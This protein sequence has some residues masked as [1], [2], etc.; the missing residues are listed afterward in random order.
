[1]MLR[2]VLILATTLILIA[3]SVFVITAQDDTLVTLTILHTNDTHS[4]HE[5]DSDGGGAAR[6]A[7]VI[8]QVRAEEDNVILLD[9]GDRFTGTL[10]HTVYLGQD[11]VRIMNLMEYDAM[12]LGNHEFD[13][14]DEVLADFVNG[15]NF[16]VLAA[17]IDFSA[18][19]IL[20]D[21]GIEQYTIVDVNG[22]QVGVIGLTTPDTPEIANPGVDLVFSDDLV[23]IANTLAA[24]LTEQ[25][26]NIIVLLTHTGINT[27]FVIAPQLEN[28]DVFVGGHSHSLLSN[29]N[30]PA[31]A[32]YPVVFTNETTEDI[33]L[34]VQAQEHYNYLGRLDLQFTVDGVADDWDGDT[35]FLSPYITPDPIMEFV[36][37]ELAEPIAAIR[38]E[39]AGATSE[40]V[41]VGDRR[42]CRV[43]ECNLGNLIADAQRA[44]TGTDVAIMNAGGIRRDLPAT[45]LTLGDVLEVQPF[46]NLVS[47]MDVTGAVLLQAIENGISGITVGE[48]GI[49]SRDGASG[50]FPQVS[51]MRFSYDP[52][53]EVGN[54]VT[55]IEIQQEDGSFAPLDPEATYSLTVPN[56]V[57][58]GGD[59]YT[60]LTAEGSNVYLFGSVDWEVTRDY[61][62]E[63][64]PIGADDGIQ[65][66]AEAPRIQL[67]NAELAPIE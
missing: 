28:I 40:V 5:G 53:L 44:H 10:F 48:G 63:I 35:I 45:D 50:R 22:V 14:G 56:F 57:A 1:M 23:T 27:D 19:P 33:V 61:M 66:D 7:T 34:Y 58:G 59:G 6:M 64:S 8:N 18:S 36:V 55:S 13:N 32:E 3:L 20:S 38:A 65:V 29:Q 31:V 62:Q 11:N 67:E 9:G 25:G 12:A 16:P 2:R 26:V 39:P 42:I 4:H 41:L 21:I 37:A 24:E 49:V 51:G 30:A 46:G 43:E 60:M 54:R 52:N 17:N 15:V 47:T